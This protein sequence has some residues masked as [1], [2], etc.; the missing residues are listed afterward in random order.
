MDRRRLTRDLEQRLRPQQVI[1]LGLAL[2]VVLYAA[3]GVALVATGFVGPILELATEI[4]AL[5]AGAGIV[6]TL[7]ATPLSRSL[8]ARA[9]AGR[10]RDPERLFDAYR[11]SILMGYALRETGAVVGFLVTLLTGNVLW[12]LLTSGIALLAMVLAWPRRDAVADWM[13]RHGRSG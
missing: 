13:V 7:A 2:S 5:A 6:L 9:E 1:C 4:Q 11:R 12:V 8:L 10:P 3:I